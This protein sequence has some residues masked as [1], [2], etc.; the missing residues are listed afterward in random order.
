MSSGRGLPTDAIDEWS[1]L[2]LPTITST[3]SMD[4]N[5][6]SWWMGAAAYD[7]DL[8][9]YADAWYSLSYGFYDYYTNLLLVVNHYMPYVDFSS[10]GAKEGASFGVCLA[11]FCGGGWYNYYASGYAYMVRPLSLYAS[12]ISMTSPDIPASYTV[13]YSGTAYYSSGD[14]LMSQYYGNWDMWYAA[15]VGE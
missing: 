11:Y 9:E 4:T 3:N 10:Y 13:Y 1:T 15:T 5:L 2:T 7:A 14:G 12:S 8:S 6:S